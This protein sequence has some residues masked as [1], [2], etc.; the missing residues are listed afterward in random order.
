MNCFQIVVVFI[1][2]LDDCEVMLMEK[3]MV[4]HPNMSFTMIWV[5][6]NESVASHEI[7]EMRVNEQ[8]VYG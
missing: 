2:E 1:G 6:E 8:F 7:K 4:V 5:L 3:R